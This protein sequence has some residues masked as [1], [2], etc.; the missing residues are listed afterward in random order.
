MTFNVSG[1]PHHFQKSPA[2]GLSR[3]RSS[4]SEFRLERPRQL[5]AAASYIATAALLHKH[6]RKR[7][8]PELPPIEDRL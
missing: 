7:T 4:F 2:L 5:G 1:R 3:A 6:S 8:L